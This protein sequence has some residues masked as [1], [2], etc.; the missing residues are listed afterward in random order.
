MAENL[1]IEN[2]TTTVV[3]EDGLKVLEEVANVTIIDAGT[4]ERVVV[5]DDSVQLL[6]QAFE[7][8]PKGP[9]GVTG[10]DGADGATGPQ[11]PPG[12]PAEDDLTFSKRVDFENAGAG[13]DFIYRGEA[14]AGSAEG[15]AVWRVR[16]I[17]VDNP[18]G[19]VTELWADGVDTFTHTWTGRLGFTYS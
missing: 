19:D 15:D 6:A 14:A 13:D 8:G 7:Q 17:F 10:A 1:V 18:E 11:G 9:A 3:I 5:F 16:R 2:N 12:D 4:P